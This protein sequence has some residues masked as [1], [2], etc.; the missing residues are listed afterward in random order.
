[1][2]Q[3]C[4]GKLHP[5]G[6]RALSWTT[7]T[8][9]DIINVSLVVFFHLL[10][11][12]LLCFPASSLPWSAWEQVLVSLLPSVIWISAQ[13]SVHPP[14]AAMGT[15][16]PIWGTKLPFWIYQFWC[17]FAGIKWTLVA[18]WI[19]PAFLAKF[20]LVTDKCKVIHHPN[21]AWGRCWHSA[22]SQRKVFAPVHH[23]H[24]TWSFSWRYLWVFYVR[25]SG[26]GMGMENVA[27]RQAWFRYPWRHEITLHCHQR[28][29]ITL[30]KNN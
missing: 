5:V 27:V 15:K 30:Y 1:M 20:F 6:I 18:R 22:L 24:H 8:W 19:E 26:E 14:E 23:L 10:F 21:C 29:E 28:K 9:E 25:T 2:L 11:T 16:S 4:Q 3:S 7:E 17:L 12:T 13:F